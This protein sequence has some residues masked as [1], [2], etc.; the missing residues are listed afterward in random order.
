MPPPGVGEVAAL[1]AR[2]RG[3]GVRVEL[4]VTGTPVP[5]RAGVDLAAY[6]VVQ[7]G[8]TNAV[9]HAAGA[10][11]RLTLGYAPGA[12]EIEVADTGGTP[13]PPAG[14][15]SG[16]G[17]IGLRQRLAVYGGTLQAGQQPAGGYVLRATIPLE[18][19]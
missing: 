6:R 3:T 4:T 7:E 15:G 5:L 12:L 17:L 10:D 19:E 8:L 9:K 14:S 1:V 18:Q 11:V 2:M 13:R 16:R